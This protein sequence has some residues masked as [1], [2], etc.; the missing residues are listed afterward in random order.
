MPIRT[1]AAGA[2][3]AAITMLLNPLQA[4][5]ARLADRLLDRIIQQEN[6]FLDQLRQ[7]NPLVETYLQEM[8]DNAEG[9]A[10]PFTDHYF[11]GKLS[12][13]GKVNYESLVERTDSKA[14][15]KGL[16][17]LGRQRFLPRGFSQMALVDASGLDR[18][19]YRF[20]Y[21]RR[22][23]LGEVRCLV[24]DVTP[25][26]EHSAGNF[27]GRI[28]VEDE[29]M[30]IVRF[31]GTY[32]NPR[33]S[34]W[35]LFS[36]TPVYFHFDSWRVN[37]GKDQWMPAFVYVEDTSPANKSQ[38]AARFK[39]QTRIWSYRP[40]D[41]R[42]AGEL[43]SV[44]I[45]SE[46][47]IHDVIASPDLSPLESQRS[48]ERQAEVNLVER[49]EKA[50]LLAPRG[51]VDKVLETVVNN[52]IV[53]N[54]LQVDAQCR[55]LM[56]TPLETFSVGNTIVVSRGLIDVLPDEASLA[57]V[58]ADEL[59]HIALG[60]RTDTQFAFH[61]QT[62]LSDAAL[63]QKL[64]LERSP[65]E[66]E[67]A[68]KRAVELLTRSPYRQRMG[69]AGLFLKAL[70]AR[71][72]SLPNLIQANLGN[73]LA[74][75]ETRLAEL[76]NLAPALEEDKLEQIAALPIGSR[77]KVDPWS[78]RATLL[79]SKPVALLSPREKMPFEVAPFVIPLAHL[80]RHEQKA[81]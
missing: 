19:R 29:G 16:W 18:R 57:M 6:T 11:L 59:A 47:G 42:K 43:T 38:G 32:T 10:R 75:S 12:L 46:T 73:Q 1:V 74:G 79:K 27:I 65:S 62:M 17:P 71:V 14:V 23:F 35:N 67:A 48:W 60:H 68:G 3:V 25:T 70:A 63:L 39:A 44:L 31:N 53:T 21:I 20:E 61:N 54:D 13:V 36:T 81:E 76:T 64:R 2:V 40:A 7:M 4:Q 51:E 52:L 45:E 55:V 77:I 9:D 30:H 26:H 33:N 24:F 5:D 66:V 37:T 72:P 78:N 22:E 69:N 41:S 56:T 15:R 58:L 28:W 49:L 50:G 34:R 80:S 8:P